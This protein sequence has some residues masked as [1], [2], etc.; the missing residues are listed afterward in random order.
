MPRMTDRLPPH[1]IDAEQ[2]VLACILTDANYA[3]PLCVDKIPAEGAFYDIKHGVLYSV[4]AGMYD[5]REPIDTATVF[6]KLRE[7]GLLEEAGGTVYLASLPEKTPSAANIDYYLRIVRRNHVLRRMIAFGR[8]S[9]AAAHDAGDEDVDTLVDDFE[10][11]ALAVS[12]SHTEEDADPPIREAV[13]AAIDKIEKF[14]AAQGKLMGLSSGFPDLD[15][16]TGGFQ[17]GEMLVVAARPSVGKT[18]FAMNIAEAVAIDQKLPVGVFSLEMS[19]VSLAMRMICSRARVNLRNVRDG[20]LAERDF[21]KITS[22]AG[23]MAS[24]NL[25]V[26]DISGLSILRLR[27]KARRMWQRYGIQLFVIDYIQLLH[28]TSKK[29]AQNR[30]V[31]IAE[32]SNGI[33]EMAKELNVPVIVLAQ[34]NRSMESASK[35][36]PRRPRM[37]D[38]RESGAIE[39]DA[40][41]IG[42]LF[43]DNLSDDDEDGDAKQDAETESITL[44]IAKQRNGPVGD[45]HLTFL[46]AYTRF[47]SRARIDAA[48]DDSRRNTKA[49]PPPPPPVTE[50]QRAFFPD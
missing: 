7:T 38:L 8:D 36:K 49:P 24:S 27:A 3:M 48:A 1:N 45:V 28:S 6:A 26:C 4:L 25:H 31:E 17:G 39:Q 20:F 23:V 11:N 21:P 35:G 37:S 10:R 46:K 19:T 5:R 42:L 34:L 43:K 32:I 29:A 40:D 30:Q 44:N 2:G 50:P 9:I 47:E 22:A 13:H 41:L 14:H 16:M 18:S 15:R 33:K 12:R